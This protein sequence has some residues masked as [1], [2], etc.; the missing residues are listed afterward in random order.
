MTKSGRKNKRGARGSL[1]DEGVLNE[2]KRP[3]MAENRKKETPDQPPPEPSR[4]QLKAI[5]ADIQV[6]V[7]FIQ[8]ENQNLKDE[9]AQLKVAFQSQKQEL[10]KMKT[11]LE[12]SAA[13]KQALKQEL[14]ATKKDLRDEIE[15]SQRLSEELDDLEQYTRKNSLEIDRVPEN[16]YT[17]TEEVVLKLGEA[18]NMPIQPDDIEIS[19]KLKARN[20]PII[21][22][23]LSHKV[24]S[25]LYKKRVELKNVKVS[26][27]FPT[28]S[29]ATAIG[30]DNRL[31]LNENRTAYRR[32]IVTKA[33]N[34]RKDDLLSSV[35]TMDGKVF[36]KTSPSGTPVRIYNVEDLDD[37]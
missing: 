19:H 28:T 16:I 27:L 33:N 10:D 34:M 13:T 4:A 31:F 24:K 1:E 17:T 2:A 21:V 23:F 7:T 30:R 36:V 11:T 32:R 26:D 8:Q 29:Y 9:I 35:W 25:N 3:N 12:K 18:L 20:N 6:K 15:E 37:L 5:L 14:E 22:K